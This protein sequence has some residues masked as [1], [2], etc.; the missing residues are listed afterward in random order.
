MLP[1]SLADSCGQ[2]LRDLIPVGSVLGLVVASS[3]GRTLA[4]QIPT[5]WRSLAFIQVNSPDPPVE[6]AV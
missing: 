3:T 5:R 2:V 4:T 6:E 1:Q